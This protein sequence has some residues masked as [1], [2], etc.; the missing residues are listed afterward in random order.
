M[1]NKKILDKWLEEERAIFEGWDFACLKGR[2][3][4]ERPPWN[5]NKLAK[6]LV[7]KTHSVLDEATG[8]GEIFST[9]APFPKHTVATEGYKPNVP[10]AKKKLSPLGVRVIYGDE[11]KK[12]PLKN[13]D[14]EL[15]LNRHGAF[16]ARE[17]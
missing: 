3:R 5:Y 11:S 13:G 4:E 2:M 12:L 7:R 6:S 1:V 8:G 9:F 14:F 17:F 15:I 10:V 16:N